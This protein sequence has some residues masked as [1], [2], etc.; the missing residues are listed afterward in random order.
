MALVD[1]EDL[2]N[3]EFFKEL[4]SNIKEGNYELV[5]LSLD[6]ARNDENLPGD[7][8]EALDEAQAK[9]FAGDQEATLLITI[10]SK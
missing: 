9:V 2:D 4:V 7:F 1:F 3:D 5:A 10:I 8:Y 6:E